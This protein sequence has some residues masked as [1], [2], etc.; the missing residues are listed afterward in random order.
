MYLRAKA[1]ENGLH[2]ALIEILVIG[3][4]ALAAWGAFVPVVVYRGH[5]AMKSQVAALKAER[6]TLS[7]NL[8]AG[9]NNLFV[10]DAAFQ[11]IS[12]LLQVFHLYRAAQ[13]GRHRVLY[14][15]A[16]PD[17]TELASAVA[18]LSNSVSGCFTFG[19]TSFGV[20][21][22]L[23]EMTK[24]DMIP[25]EIVV[26]VQRGDQAGITLQE[27]LTSLIQGRLS[28]TPPKIPQDRL[29][30][31]TPQDSSLVWLQ[32]GTGVKWNSEKYHLGK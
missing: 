32:F 17:S 7:A 14:L 11:S 5:N 27:Q 16:M 28:Y 20:N 1:F 12:R 8:D 26:H 23:D 13:K 31:G 9:K 6:D 15:T 19:P 3:T 25:N 10:R 30:A 18:Q 4:V 24:A 2:D 21:P 29:Y 22:D